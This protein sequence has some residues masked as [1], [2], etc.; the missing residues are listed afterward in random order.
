M[1]KDYQMA[2]KLL[3]AQQLFADWRHNSTASFELE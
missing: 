2:K 1:A 3:Y